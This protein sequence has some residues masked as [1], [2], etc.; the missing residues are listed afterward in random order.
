MK[1]PAERPGALRWW[2]WGSWR[3]STGPMSVPTRQAR[4]KHSV[5]DK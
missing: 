1:R 5:L 2:G 3:P 4:H